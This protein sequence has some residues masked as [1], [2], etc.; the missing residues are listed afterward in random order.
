MTDQPI[1]TCIIVLNKDQTKLLLGKRKNA[2]RAGWYGTPGGR[3]NPGEPTQKSAIRE[4]EEE[5]GVKVDK[6]RYLGIAKEFQDG[7]DFIHFGFVCEQHKGEIKNQ[8]PE[9][10]EGWEWFGLNHLP[11]KIL[12]GHKVLIDMYRQQNP[13]NLVDC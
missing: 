10:C 13:I 6:L 5:T 9:K 1:G 4:L 3:I 8:E 7:F 12:T 11:K 2:F